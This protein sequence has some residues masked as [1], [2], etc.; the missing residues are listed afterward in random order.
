MVNYPASLDN[1]GNL[2][3]VH[4]SLR[5]VLAADYNPGDTSISVSGDT[6]T[7]VRW[8]A[9]GLITLTEQCSDLD[10][11]AISFYYSSF[12]QTNMII[13]G[14]ELL[15][16]FTDVI[17]P[18]NLTNVTISVMDRHHDNLKDALIAIQKF[19]GVQGTIDA[20]PMGDTLEGRINYLRQSV[21]QPKAWFTSD[22]QTGNVPLEVEFDNMSFRLATDG[23]E[24]GVTV[25]WDFGDHTSSTISL[26]SIISA[27]SVVPDSPIDVLVREV[28]STTIKKIYHQP[29][30]YNV[31]LTVT[32]NFGSDVITFNNY[33]TARVKMPA[34]AIVSLIENTSSQLSMPGVPPN[35][36]FIATP[37]IRS[38][39]NTLIQ[40]EV[41]QGENPATPGVSYAGE[42]LNGSGQPI[43]PVTNYTWAL[44]DDLNHP[45][46]TET[47]ASYSVG[48]IYDMKLRVDT[49]FGAYRITTYAGA[50]DIVEN[51]NLWLWTYLDPI[52]TRAYEYGLISE[53]FK[54]TAAPTLAVVRNSTF[55]NNLPNVNQQLAEFNRNTGFAPR[56][57]TNSGLGGTALLYWATGRNVSDPTTT[58]AIKVVEFDG[59][60]G[61]YINQ[62]T[63]QRQWNWANLNAPNN[64]Y[65]LFGTGPNTLPNESPTN[66][67]IQSIE[68][69]LLL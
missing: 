5:F 7:A 6:V 23:T 43:D 65:F 21:L 56:G 28:G 14:L 16:E 12:D 57:N 53:T 50:I 47:K 18:K 25:T 38:P 51:V 32:N 48:G 68:F 40:I 17:K 44:A 55:L 30:I 37:S 63:I 20:G 66:T 36:P 61:T 58:E 10:H 29:G 13:N 33:I 41:E 19:G 26:T 8:P 1:I 60:T 15:P 35:G 42:T 27:N 22:V 4:D 52:N 9:S 3:D 31:T 2:F 64:S 39:I 34:P 11:R 62:P 46:S 59:F 45:N 69:M 67:T 24:S 49:A 54:L